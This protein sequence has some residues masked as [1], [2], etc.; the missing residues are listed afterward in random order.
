MASVAPGGT[1][2][3]ESLECSSYETLDQ[4]TPSPPADRIAVSSTVNS[5]LGLSRLG[6]GTS[7][8]TAELGA[9]LAT[10]DSCQFIEFA[11]PGQWTYPHCPARAG[12]RMCVHRKRATQPIAYR[13]NSSHEKTSA[14]LGTHV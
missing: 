9:E 7:R 6:G 13:S 12:Y 8:R 2:G 1:G 5:H 4:H 10:L 3:R 14:N 11:R